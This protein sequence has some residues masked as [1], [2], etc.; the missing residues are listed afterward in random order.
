MA[1]EEQIFANLGTVQNPDASQST[2]FVGDGQ[3]FV[4]DEQTNRLFNQ[5]TQQQIAKR[6][7]EVADWEK[8]MSEALT[9]AS[10]V[11]E[12]LYGK[13]IDLFREEQKKLIS[14]IYKNP[15]IFAGQ[16]PKKEQEFTQKLADLTTLAKKSEN[17]GKTIQKY[18]ELMARNPDYDNKLM[19][20]GIQKLEES[21]INE[22]QNFIFTPIANP[23]KDFIEKTLPAWQK[24]T[25]GELINDIQVSP[26]DANVDIY[27]TKKKF[28]FNSFLPIFKSQM[29]GYLAMEYNATPE[30]K[31]SELYPTA[32]DYIEAQAK[33]IFEEEKYIGNPVYK[34]N[35]EKALDAKI[36]DREDRQEQQITIEGIK[37]ENRQAVKDHAS[38][39]YPTIEELYN[40][41]DIISTPD[42]SKKITITPENKKIIKTQLGVEIDGDF[43]DVT[44]TVREQ[45]K[46]ADIV[47]GSQKLFMKV[48][49]KG[50]KTFYESSDGTKGVNW[51]EPL[52]KERL[53]QLQAG[54]KNEKDLDAYNK[55]ISEANKPES[56]SG[57]KL[58]SINLLASAEKYKDVDYSIGAKGKNNKMDCS[59]LVCAILNDNGVK[60]SGTSEDIVVNAPMKPTITKVS[61]F[62]VGDVIGID[63]GKT[64][65]DKG[66]KNGIDHIGIVIE[67][68]GKLFF[69]ESRGSKG[70]DMTPL[71]EKINKYQKANYELF[72]GRYDVE[73]PTTSTKTPTAKKGT[74]KSKSG[75]KFTVE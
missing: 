10:K 1:Y 44:E 24:T 19:R 68:D 72:V 13:D 63:S 69:T 5:I 47:E 43:Y 42:P 35:E 34:R 37:F 50:N 4:I 67:K 73:S 46:Y 40:Q 16:N 49:K 56:T 8:G 45:P 70:F 62:K 29:G 33:N 3:P 9:T 36:A 64:S 59:G 61:D 71:D 55:F 7:K 22:S 60:A 28:N 74:Y 65:F 51:K 15:E 14:E 66:R 32:D 6:E 11:P 18:R 30:L 75:I 23:T 25:D 17:R 27:R 57:T 48:D 20:D 52:T 38:K 58:N 53:I 41:Y 54:E 12:N 31:N 26:N 39:S 21:D 2:Q